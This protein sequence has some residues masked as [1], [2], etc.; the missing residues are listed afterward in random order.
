MS[1]TRYKQPIY[2]KIGH[3][4]VNIISPQ[5]YTTANPFNLGLLSS[6]YGDNAFLLR[7]ILLLLL[8]LLTV[9]ML[10]LSVLKLLSSI[11]LEE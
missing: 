10:L 1:R 11:L 5:S 8:L 7:A 4:S 2:Q 3:I 6:I 9:L